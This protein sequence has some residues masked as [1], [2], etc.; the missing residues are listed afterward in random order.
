MQTSAFLGSARSQKTHYF[1]EPRKRRRTA[2]RDSETCVSGAF[3]PLLHGSEDPENVAL[4]QRL[5]DHVWGLQLAK[6]EC[7]LN[8][9]NTAL[10]DQ[11][12]EFIMG[13]GGAKLPVG[14]LL[15]G[16]NTAN[17]LRILN[18][19]DDYLRNHSAA[20]DFLVIS[21]NSKSCAHIKATVREIIKQFFNVVGK[22]PSPASDDD[23]DLNGAANEA[24]DIEDL[25]DAAANR[26]SYD[27]DVVEDW[28][29]VHN[30][31]TRR[32]VITI[33]DSDS[34]D[35]NVL[36]QLLKLLQSYWPT[37]PIRLIMGLSSASV[38][39]WINTNLNNQV[40]TVI[41]GF[42]FRSNDNRDLGYRVIEDLFLQ[43]EITDASPLGL[44]SRLSLVILNRFENA[45]NSIDSL[46]AELK[47]SYMIF[48]YQLPL[49][50]LILDDGRSCAHIDCLRKLPSFKKYVEFKLFRYLEDKRRT[51][52]GKPDEQVLK[53][54]RA[55]IEALLDSNEALLDLFMQARIDFQRYQLAV[56]NAV[57][58]LYLL[59]PLSTVK[60]EKFKIYKLVTNNQLV[61]SLYLTHIL[62]P[63]KTFSEDDTVKTI[64][65]LQLAENIKQGLSEDIH[66]DHMV[67]LRKNVSCEGI[68]NT[69]LFNELTSYFHKNE[70][71]NK[72]ID[73]NLFNEV[74]TINGGR[75]E[76]EAL[77]PDKIIEENFEN[78]M[79]HLVRPN[80]RSV[81]E[82]EFEEPHTFLANETV[83][84]DAAKTRDDNNVVPMV[85]K[86]Y[87]IYKDAPI[88]VNIYDFF[89]AFR[90]SVNKKN[91]LAELEA[92]L[93]ASLGD[94]D[95]DANSHRLRGILEKV[96]E[97]EDSAAWDKLLYA[98]F[99]QSCYELI[100]I[101]L[102][103][104][105]TN[106]DFLEKTVW[107]GV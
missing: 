28:F 61:N 13:P 72:K 57:N 48:F 12:V 6:V 102:L 34:V 62:K 39:N 98:W 93:G 99:V 35:H 4:R 75:S 25:V 100:L 66:D 46:I 104:E 69:I 16:S 56:V 82:S 19:F 89:C 105:K 59:S 2:P 11:L 49:S 29:L 23:E 73:D 37:L 20:S 96:R 27:F 67:T 21:V 65:I 103:K 101:G 83:I 5:F 97:E 70:H 107:K 94:Q 30:S 53:A 55:H 47:L 9:T 79:S 77:K 26:V 63:I 76:S 81:L 44:D 85:S 71:L 1:V 42:K 95:T 22:G 60:K 90:E 58:L 68:T 43:H 41:S 36:N 7:I 31:P 87:S 8:N 38:S 88:A 18:E 14:F 40:R 50:S 17:N 52:T 32:L 15:L 24:D 86:L 84:A 92:N 78:L 74:L 33:Q 10:F 80:L 91:V 3:T 54:S 45:N 51:D 106:G 64:A